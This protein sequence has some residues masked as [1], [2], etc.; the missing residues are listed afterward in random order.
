[1]LKIENSLL[2]SFQSF[3]FFIFLSNYFEYVNA[4]GRLFDPVA[5]SSAWRKDK[6]FPAYYNDMVYE[7]FLYSDYL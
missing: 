3:L 1:M 5:R 2:F 4:H 7:Y 6:S